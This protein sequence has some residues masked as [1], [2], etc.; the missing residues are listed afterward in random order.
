MSPRKQLSLSAQPVVQ[1][2]A[3]SSAFLLPEFLRQLRD[4]RMAPVAL[5]LNSR[6]H[7]IVL[8]LGVV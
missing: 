6:V 3:E 5:V 7:I 4:F 8:S 2:T 1:V